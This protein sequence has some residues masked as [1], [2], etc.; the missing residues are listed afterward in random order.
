MLSGNAV[1]VSRSLYL[2]SFLFP[3]EGRRGWERWEEWE[4][5]RKRKRKIKR[6]RK[7]EENG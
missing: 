1:L 3:Q 6:K 2:S 4:R 5:K 7:D